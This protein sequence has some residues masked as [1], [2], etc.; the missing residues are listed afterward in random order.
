VTGKEKAMIEAICECLPRSENQRNKLFEA[1]AEIIGCP[2]VGFCPA[3]ASLV[4]NIDEFSEEDLLR[5]E[6]PYVLGWNM[7]VGVISDILAVGGTPRY[8]G[9]SLVISDSWSRE[10]VAGL[11]RGIAGVLRETGTAFLGGDLGISSAWRYTGSA[12]GEQQGEPLMRSRALPGDVIYLTGLIGRGNLA[13]A[14]K[15]FQ[16][17]PL[18]VVSGAEGKYTFS[19]RLR[20]AGLIKK[21]SRCCIDTSDGVLNSLLAVSEQ[22]GTG[23]VVEGLPYLRE[24]I[25]L[26]NALEIPRELLFCGECGEYE[27]LF[28]LKKD[29]EEAFLREAREQGLQFYRLGEVTGPEKAFLREQDKVLDLADFKLRARD[30]R[31]PREYLRKIIDFVKKY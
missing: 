14:L 19:L 30:Y 28:T 11:A 17:E 18:P 7:A 8:Y 10:Y 2:T 12:I 15:I 29:L 27:L 16:T 20:E 5:E 25:L 23:F 1:D 22:S 24:G 13:A 4:F 9:H 3:G 21:Y 6:D 26:A 31:E